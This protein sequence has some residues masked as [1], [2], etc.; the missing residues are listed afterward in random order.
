MLSIYY[1]KAFNR[2]PP[3]KLTAYSLRRGAATAYY[4]AGTKEAHLA[5]LLRHSDFST[6]KTYID[7]MRTRAGRLEVAAKVLPA[8]VL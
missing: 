2:L 5:Q 6:T 3:G 4:L 8:D 1:A 7:Q